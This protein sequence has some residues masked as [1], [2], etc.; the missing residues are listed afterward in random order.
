P[1]FPPDSLSWVHAASWEG[2]KDV[3]LDQIDFSNKSAWQ[4]SR[5]PEKVDL[6]ANEISAGRMK[7]VILVQRPGIPKLMI[8]YGHHR[9]L[10]YLNLGRPVRAF[11]GRVNQDHGPWD[12]MHAKQRTIFEGSDTARSATPGSNLRP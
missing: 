1:D 4:A 12:E 10:A 5:E 3:P 7:P 2:P 8:P 6:F 9:A 11:V